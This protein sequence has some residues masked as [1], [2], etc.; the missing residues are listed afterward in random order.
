VVHAG[1]SGAVSIQAEA[2]NPLRIALIE[3]PAKVDY[4]LHRDGR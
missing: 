2:D 4:P 1:E 3:V